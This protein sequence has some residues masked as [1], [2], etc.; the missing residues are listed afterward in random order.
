MNLPSLL[1]EEIT[2]KGIGVF[3]AQRSTQS[4]SPRRR[5]IFL[6]AFLFSVL[7]S[8]LFSQGSRAAAPDYY[9]VSEEVLPPR[10]ASLQPAEV[11]AEL[12]QA[13][14]QLARDLDLMS[15][16]H[17]PEELPDPPEPYNRKYHYGTWVR[18]PRDGGCLNTRGKVLV[19]SSEIP[20]TFNARGCTVI[21][22]RWQDPYS[23]QTFSDAR[24]LQIDHVV[25]LKNSYINGGWKWN[26]S[27]RCLYANF[28]GNDFH[29][30]AVNGPDNMEKG[31][32]TPEQ[33]M[34]PHSAFACEYLSDWL[35]IKLIWN[36]ALGPSEARAIANLVKQNHCAGTGL[37]MSQQDLRQQRQ[38]ILEDGD[39]CHGLQ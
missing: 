28:L 27:L 24:D 38:R 5:E 8:V 19:R 16:V 35:K 25:P 9:T 7:F 20:V 29:L 14:Q 11:F 36:L 21:R 26:P 2:L 15:W 23:G 32:R 6:I 33:F 4:P 12:A 31:D 39:L 1:A 34:P 22:G 3:M 18:D 13:A 37:S 30:R 17:H 10:Q